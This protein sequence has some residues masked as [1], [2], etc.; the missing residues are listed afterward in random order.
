MKLGLQGVSVVV[1]SG[2]SGVGGRVGQNGHTN[3][4]LG[5][6]GKVF[7]PDYPGTCPYLTMVGST[8]IPPG[9]SVST[10]GSEVATTSFSSGGG[11]SNIYPIPDY[12]KDA[13]EAYFTNAD[14]IVQAYPYYSASN[15][16]GVGAN[17]GIYN[18]NG[19][20]YPDVSAL[21]DNILVYAYGQQALYGGTSASAPIFASILNRI[22][23]ERL[24]AG[25][26]TVGFVNPT[27]YAHPEAFN[28][29]TK[30]NNTACGTAGFIASTGWDPL[31]GLGTPKYSALLDLFMSLP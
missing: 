13:V 29:V 17:G 21:G 15:L 18:R 22:N 1:A 12:Q 5:D 26:S 20:G 2:D 3:G 19:R 25:K 31:T 16:T 10:E 24:A 9:G 6:D 23:E 8:Y 27:L 14:P 4:C 11:F 28:D 30:G 7:N